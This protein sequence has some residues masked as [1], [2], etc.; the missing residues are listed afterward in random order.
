MPANNFGYA[1]D[2]ALIAPSV[3]ALNQL[4]AICD[5]F[6]LK[7]IVFS[8]AKSVC[9]MIHAGPRARL[10]PPSVYQYLSGATLQ[11][12]ESFRYLGHVITADFKD[13]ADIQREMKSLNVRGNV[14]L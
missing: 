10:T 12:V 1:D 5:N 4:L 6:A 7:H 13:D 14:I 9:M 8:T 3:K 11:F 2:L